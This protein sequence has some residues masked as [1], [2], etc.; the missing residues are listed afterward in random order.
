MTYQNA[1]YYTYNCTNDWE[2]LRKQI[3][4]DDKKEISVKLEADSSAT[5]KENFK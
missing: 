5:P 4:E 2:A 3:A 1:W